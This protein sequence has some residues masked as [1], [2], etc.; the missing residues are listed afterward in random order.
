MIK[1]TINRNGHYRARKTH[2]FKVIPGKSICTSCFEFYDGKY[3]WTCSYCYVAVCY[4]C[5]SATALWPAVRLCISC[6]S[7]L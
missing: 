4:S 1:Y 5:T 6:R 2:R 7:G 3:G